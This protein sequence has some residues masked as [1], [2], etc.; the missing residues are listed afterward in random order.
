MKIGFFD[1][2]KKLHIIL[3]WTAVSCLALF[4]ICIT[5]VRLNSDKIKQTFI[6]ELNKHL[7]TEVKVN[8]I[9]IGVVSSFPLV[10]VSFYDIFIA[11][12]FE[13]SIQNQDTLASL[14]ELN[15]KFKLSDIL[16]GKYNIRKIE[17]IEGKAKLKVLKSGD[18]NYRFWKSDTTS[19]DSDFAFSIKDI[20]IE[21][22]SLE[23]QNEI[24]KLFVS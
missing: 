8:E 14:K 12:A 24:S 6:K 7:L 17:A 9:D 15:L 21:D 5:F 18:C 22:L 10:S 19:T 13:D 4:L 23:Y 3:F 20:T 11:D 2:K 16:T 1:S